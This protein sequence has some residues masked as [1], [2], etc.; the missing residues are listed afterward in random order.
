MCHLNG[1]RLLIVENE[2]MLADDLVQAVRAAGA[3]VVGPAATEAR[4][5]ALIDVEDGL[6]GAVLDVN[7]HGEISMVLADRLR[8]LSVPFV[9]ATGYGQG[10]FS[11][12]HANVPRWEK[13]YDARELAAA[14]PS[15]FAPLARD[16]TATR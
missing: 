3:T 9:F 4:A 8:D 1:L 5:M 12:E 15:L 2:Y 7:L 11:G 16:R 10:S 6:D 13:P 14:L